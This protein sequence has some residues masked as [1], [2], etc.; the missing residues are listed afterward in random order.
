[1]SRLFRSELIRFPI[2]PGWQQIE[3]LKYYF[4]AKIVGGSH[5]CMLVAHTQLVASYIT[6][7]HIPQVLMKPAQARGKYVITWRETLGTM[8]LDDIQTLETD[9]GHG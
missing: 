5:F 4:L 1:M 6:T 2:C 9:A 3:A 7:Y 8:L